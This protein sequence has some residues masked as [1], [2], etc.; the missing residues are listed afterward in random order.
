MMLN[1]FHG[2]NGE[3]IFQKWP[4]NIHRVREVDVLRELV[5]ARTRVSAAE[6]CVQRQQN[7]KN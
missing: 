1:Q 4:S 6:V 3:C 2:I 7:D 5:C